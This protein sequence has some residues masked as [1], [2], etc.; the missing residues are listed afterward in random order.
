MRF[1]YLAFKF[2]LNQD[3]LLGLRYTV[4]RLFTKQNDAISTS[5]PLENFVFPISLQSIDSFFESNVEKKQSLFVLADDF[6]VDHIF[7][8]NQKIVLEDYTTTKYKSIIKKGI[9]YDKD[10]RFHWEIYRSKI[11]FHVGLAYHL[12]KEEKYAEALICNL[13]EW[14]RYCPIDDTDVPYN[15]M[16][17]AIKIINLSWIDLFLTK[18]KG[19]TVDTQKQLSKIIFL[20]AEYI[21]KNY[22][23]SY[24]GLESNHSISCNVGL[25]YAGVFLQENKR[26]KKWYNFG[27]KNLKRNLKT[28]FT[29]DGVNFESSVHYHRYVFEILVFIHEILKNNKKDPGKYLS[30]RITDIGLALKKLTHVNDNISRFGDNDGGK[31]LFDFGTSEEFNNLNYLNY[32]GSNQ[33]MCFENLIVKDYYLPK[34]YV[35]EHKSLNRIGKYV[36]FKGKDISL[37]AS[38]ND[39]GTNGK[40]NH[41]HNDF[42][43]FELYG[44]NPFIVDPWSYCYTGNPDLRNKDRSIESH[45][46][47]EIDG[48]EVVEF[49]PNRL[50]EMLGNIRTEIEELS[51]T[52]RI[53][54]F[55]LSHNGYYNLKA[56]RQI[57][58][59]TFD[60]NKNNNEINIFDSLKG[61]GKH[62]AIIKFHIPQKYFT[63]YQKDTSLIFKNDLEEFIISSNQESFNITEGFVSEHFLNRSPSYVLSLEVE[64]NNN[65][66]ITTNI[67]YLKV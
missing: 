38:A 19:Y 22:E 52:E 20:L 35:T 37:I 6:L 53:A 42:L 2:F 50:F 61:I 49:D 60:I 23:I 13:S 41:Q 45:N 30:K 28:Q 14:K 66:N 63:M 36:S 40:G 11:L 5:T 55:T 31:F 29:P 4:R 9:L 59:R 67:K 18:Y 62:K 7:I 65:L 27:M 3:L 16:E 46:S 56:G 10:I 33:S 47:I 39:I 15:G 24:Y 54:S 51:D 32:T 44:V 64:Y 57:H 17:A 12:T 43:S 1:I 21:Y 34:S 8:Y 58:K 26:S 48:R 25:I